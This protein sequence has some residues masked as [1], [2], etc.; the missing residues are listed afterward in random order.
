MKRSY[1]VQVTPKADKPEPP[2]FQLLNQKNVTVEALIKGFLESR[3]GLS[4]TTIHYYKERLELFLLYL[5][6]ENIKT[7]EEVSAP[8]IRNYLAYLEV[9]RGNNPGAQLCNFRAVR[10]MLFWWEKETDDE[11]RAPIRKVKAPKVKIEPI[12]GIE[13]EEIQQLIDCCTNGRCAARDRAIFSVLFD[14]GARADELISLNLEDVNMV[15]G[16]VTIRHGKG[17]KKRYVFLGVK[18]RRILRTYLKE[19]TGLRP[20]DPVFTKETG[21]RIT[22][23]TLKQLCERRSKEAKLEGQPYPHDFR[24]AF[25]LTLWRNGTDIVTISRLMGHSTLEVLKR[26]LAQ[27][28]GDLARAH[29]QA[30]PVDT[31]LR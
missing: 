29:A 6:R 30:S 26:Y 20:F 31:K 2:A 4:P 18:A 24:R 3:R 7:I 15:T 5:S 25:A 12:P 23:W 17:D 1:N 8:T 13:P 21:A 19:R 14:T 28:T 11:Y 10:A 22:Y 16:E 27:E 9:E